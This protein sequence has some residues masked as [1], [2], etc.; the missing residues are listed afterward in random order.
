MVSDRHNTNRMQMGNRLTQKTSY[1][2]TVFPHKAASLQTAVLFF[3]LEKGE[4]S[5]RL[6]IEVRRDRRVRKEVVF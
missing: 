5:M 1:W 2:A 3:I 6:L 4:E